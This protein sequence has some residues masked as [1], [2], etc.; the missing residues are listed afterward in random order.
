MPRYGMVI[1]LERCIGCQACTVACKME[2]SIEHNSWINVKMLDGQPLDTAVGQFPNLTMSYLPVTCMHCQNPPCVDSCPIDAIYK[3]VDGVV[4]LEPS[5]CNGCESCFSA[6]PYDVILWDDNAGVA[7]K[8]HLCAHRIGEGLEPF[9][10]ICCE[11][12]AIHFGDFSDPMSEVSLLVANRSGYVLK[13]EEE[14]GP[15]VYYLPPFN[16]RPL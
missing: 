10:A 7:T 9:C 4:I 15:S 3:R 16:K 6:C 13:P 5:L 12:Q 2:N 11:G 1:D 14:T 8:C